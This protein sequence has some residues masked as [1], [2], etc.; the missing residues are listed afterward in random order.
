MKRKKKKIDEDRPKVENQEN[1]AFIDGAPTVESTEESKAEVVSEALEDQKPLSSEESVEK[2]HAK[3]MAEVGEEPVDSLYL[4][5]DHLRAQVDEYLDGWQ[6]SRA[7]F[8]NYKKRTEREREEFRAKIKGE[9]LIR[10]L[11]VFDDLDRAL[12]DIP[13]DNENKA[14]VEGIEL[15]HLKLSAILEAEGV[16]QIQAE[17]EIFDPNFHE[18]ISYEDTDDHQ[19]G[20]VIEVIKHGY[21]LG[22]HVLRP[23]VVRVAK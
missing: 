16:E 14:W 8:A 11:D 4:E 15:I 18:A 2:I 13:T 21:K 6:R 1:H 23:A 12:L 22:D 5:I 20:Q 7:E 10:Y 3:V 17:G 19:D 9:I